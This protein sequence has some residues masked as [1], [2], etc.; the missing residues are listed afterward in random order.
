MHSYY[1]IPD[2]SNYDYVLKLVGGLID[3]RPELVDLLKI[4]DN[5]GELVN[6]VPENLFKFDEDFIKNNLF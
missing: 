4:T 1:E 3:I 6:Y 2:E 5:S